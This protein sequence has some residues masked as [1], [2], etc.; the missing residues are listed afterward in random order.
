MSQYAPFI[1]LSQPECNQ[2]LGAEA[3]Y[4]K[5][6]VAGSITDEV[7][8]FF[9]LSNTYSV[10]WPWDRLCDLVVRVPGC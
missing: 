7:I 6:K 3:L 9:I 2:Q 1:L 5:P 8:G 10:P 4:Y